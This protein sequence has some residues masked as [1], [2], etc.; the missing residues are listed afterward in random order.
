MNVYYD[1]LKINDKNYTKSSK[2][3]AQG[4]SPLEN[5]I[6]EKVVLTNWGNI[7]YKKA[8]FTDTV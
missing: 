1:S 8:M 6:S 5:Q 4:N 7:L 3:V 2:N